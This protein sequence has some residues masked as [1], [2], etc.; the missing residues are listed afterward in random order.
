MM[1]RKLFISAGVAA[2]AA[3]GVAGTAQA[4]VAP[5]GQLGRYVGSTVITN[6]DTH[7]S[8]T[9][10]TVDMNVQLDQTGYYHEFDLTY[11]PAKD[12]VILFSGVGKQFD[13]GGELIT[14]S[15]DTTHHTVT[16][17]AEYVNENGTKMGA[18]NVWDVTDAPLDAT[19]TSGDI[20]WTGNWN[21]YPLTGGFHNVPAAAPAPV[22]GNHGQYVSGAVKAGIKG[23]ALTAIAQDSNLVGPYPTR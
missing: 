10:N 9:I 1:L 5:D 6:P 18:A 23:K 20:D 17:K 16:W 15:L 22:T 8:T 12:G 3:V 21:G 14:G 13:N 2:V 4:Y 19:A 11:E 7:A